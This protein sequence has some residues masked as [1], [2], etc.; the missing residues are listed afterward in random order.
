MSGGF[1][2]DLFNRTEI[3]LTS[4]GAALELEQLVA[5]GRP[6]NRWYVSTFDG[7]DNNNGKSWTFPFATM[8]A[9]LSAAQ[10][11]DTIYFRGDVR[12]ELTGSNLKFDITIVGVGSKHH[13]DQPTSLYDPGA[14]MWRPPASPTTATPLL[15]VRG[16]GWNFVNVTFDCPVD[17]AAVV[18]SRN[19]L[20]G[21]SEYDA[22]HASFLGCRFL[23][24]KYGIEDAGGCYNV[25]VQGNQFLGMST[26]AIVNTSTAVA[27][28]LNWK[29]L[30]NQFPS[31]VSI[32]NATH[33]DSPLNEAVI[34][35]NV[36]GTVTSTA[37]Y[38]DLTGTTSPGPG[39]SGSGTG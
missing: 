13:P 22:S 20:S 21:A 34:K 4:R 31:Y 8:S 26:T 2:P 36:F 24:G 27:N 7:S 38:I 19:A 33:I 10:T 30:D 25:T 35:G 12:E 18:L 6:G 37:A 3:A 23:S 11:S 14:S 39:T 28:P 15:T 17:A 32:G 16:R 1:S 9:A 5:G 29:I